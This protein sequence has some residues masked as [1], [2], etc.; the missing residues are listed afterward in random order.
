MPIRLRP[1]HRPKYRMYHLCNHPDGCYLMA[2]NML[3]RKDE[4]YLTIQQKGSP[5]LFD[6]HPDIS[7]STENQ[8]NTNDSIKGAVRSFTKKYSY[9]VPIKEFYAEFF[10][11]HG[12]ICEIVLLRKL[13]TEMSHNGEL[14]IIRIPHQTMYG[15]PT[16]FWTTSKDQKIFLK[17][18]HH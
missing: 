8:W 10:S 14:E 1:N 13:L 11:E 2:E 9:Q 6:S 16:A 12:L 5:T 18:V 15:K 3:K 4:L 7:Q 17:S